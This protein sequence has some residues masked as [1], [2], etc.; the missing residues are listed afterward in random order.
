M[1]IRQLTVIASPTIKRFGLWAALLLAFSIP[2]P[3]RINSVVIVTFFSIFTLLVLVTGE[4]ERKFIRSPLF[5][6][7]SVLFV[8]GGIG[9]IFTSDVV[10]GWSDIERSSFQI[11]FLL[12]IYQFRVL[13]ISV[14]KLAV[15]FTIG[16]F[17]V[18]IYGLSYAL[19]FLKGDTQ[20]EVFELGHTSFSDIILIHPV[21]LSLYFIFSFFF[22]LETVRTRSSTLNKASK[23][24]I[25]AALIFIIGI[26][27]FL[28]AQM[29][30]LIFVM[31]LVMYTIIILKKRAWLITFVLFT[32][33][34]LVFLLDPYRVT[35]FFD[36][37]G[38]NVSSA[39]D[40]RFSVWRGTIEGIKTALFFG[41]GTGGEQELINRGYAKT[42]YQEGIYNSYNAHNQYL[43]FMARNGILELGC[44]L[45]LLIYSFR[46]SLKM[47]NYT[48]L[49]FNMTVTLI[50]FTESFLDVQRGIVFFYFFLCAFIYL[51][52]E[53][54]S[55]SVRNV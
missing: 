19:L 54:A 51:P 42:G 14:F 29:S 4:I 9:L 48:F 11:A 36:T 27:M 28:R 46:Q 37:Y 31:L 24:G 21:Y 49:M 34:L 8:I 43:Q 53:S 20:K 6:L 39:L 32:I 26:L 40:Q 52:Y 10:K 16:C 7:V 12:L 55:Q 5:V 45:A 47:P 50:M 35:T 18:T 13:N 38:K 1:R 22:L 41:A 44:F 33:A 17:T 30:L 3:L 25:A 2:F 15:A 23:L